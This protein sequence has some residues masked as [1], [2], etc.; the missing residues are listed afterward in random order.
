MNYLFI[1]QNMPGQF[2]HLA[3]RLADDPH[4]RVFFLTQA[5]R[6]APPGVTRVRYRP[7]RGAHVSTHHY[8]RNFETAVLNGQAVARACLN[9]KDAGF[10]PDVI[11]AHPGWGESL[12]VKDVHPHAKY[13]NYC[14]FFYRANGA[15]VGFDRDE[16][17]DAD[18]AARIRTRNA[19]LMI[20]LEA[21]DRGVSPTKWQREVH[22]AE[23]HS[24]IDVVFDGIDAARI[25]PDAQA[26]FRLTDGTELMRHDQVVTYVARGLEP[27]RGFPSFMRAVPH[28]LAELPAAHVLVVGDDAVS[29]GSRP[30][31]ATTWREAMLDELGS[32]PPRL[33]FLGHLP[34]DDYVRAL[35][36]S[37]AHIYL[38]VPFVLSW[39][40][41]EAL[42]AGCIVIGS[43]TPPVEE[44]I[45][46]GENGILVDFFSPD[47]IARG[48]IEA[49]RR[50]S[51]L[52]P[53]R[54]EARRSIL[55]HYDLA[56]CLPRQIDL[57]RAVAAAEPAPLLRARA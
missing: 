33:H 46:D 45:R 9:L 13:I 14:E 4:N 54:C 36:V 57:L 23:W 44:V 35:Q 10:V 27:Y 7:V 21:C 20:A 15:D 24:K 2:G 34:Y 55:G 1:H 3:A 49:V 50:R 28:I 16:P 51:E 43:R 30:K 42:A 6:P 18:L 12:Y 5:D 48:V 52:E 22:P 11:I 25:R 39:S 38:T 40:A 17:V 26:R 37:S 19:A 32:M 56:T 31:G 41:M 53:M 29:Y 47:A 8:I